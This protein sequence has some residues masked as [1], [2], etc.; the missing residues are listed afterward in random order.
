MKMLVRDV[1]VSRYRLSGRQP[2][3]WAVGAVG[4]LPFEGV[5]A[6]GSGLECRL[7]RCAH[8]CPPAPGKGLKG[9]CSARGWGGKRRPICTDAHGRGFLGECLG[10]LVSQAKWVQ[11]LPMVA[12]CWSWCGNN[13]NAH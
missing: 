8:Q 2:G 12:K 4:I 3:S 10:L 7:H 6:I 13:P 11:L 9:L 5:T 1:H